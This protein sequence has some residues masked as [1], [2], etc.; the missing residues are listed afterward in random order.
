MMNTGTLLGT[1]TGTGFLTFPVLKVDEVVTG[2]REIGVS[3]TEQEVRRPTHQTVRAVYERMVTIVTGAPP[4]TGATYEMD[5]ASLSRNMA[6][7]LYRDA[8]AETA[9]INQMKKICE[10]C[11][12]HDFNAY[13]DLHTPEPGRVLKQFS[14]FI[15]YAKYLDTKVERFNPLFND[16]EEAEEECHQAQEDAADAE[17]NLNAFRQ[18]VEERKGEVQ[19]ARAAVD[20]AEAHVSELSAVT[21]GLETECHDSSATLEELQNKRMQLES[22]L[23]LLR[24]ECD[25]LRVQIVDSPELLQQNIAET[26]TD[27]EKEQSVKAKEELACTMLNTRLSYVT[28]MQD[29]VGKC[30]QLQLELQDTMKAQQTAKKDRNARKAEQ[31]RLYAAIR[32]TDAE[33]GRL[34]AKFASASERLLKLQKQH[35]VQREQMRS[36]LEL[37]LQEKASTDAEIAALTDEIARIKAD[38]AEAVHLTDV[39]RADKERDTQR[40]TQ[41]LQGLMTGLNQYYQN[42]TAAIQRQQ[43][44]RM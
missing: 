37:L 12:V 40:L 24:Q 15:N 29:K 33:I 20:E 19:Q 42:I 2:L 32:D 35:D 8:L 26:K 11:N 17:R 5:W 6:P 43:Q 44:T 13:R 28:S 4:P 22:Q 10:Q 41:S 30:V 25:G 1:H 36:E 31:A 16:L 39:A 21:R 9:F 7:D 34:R 3:V 23:N 18:M 27:T 14:G 38:I